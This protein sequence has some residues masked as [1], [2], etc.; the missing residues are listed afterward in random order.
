MQIWKFLK[1]PGTFSNFIQELSTQLLKFIYQAPGQE[2]P[3]VPKSHRH[4]AQRRHP[5]GRQEDARE[6]NR[7]EDGRHQLNSQGAESVSKGHACRHRGGFRQSIRLAQ[8]GQRKN[9]GSAEE[10]GTLRQSVP[11]GE[12]PTELQLCKGP[13]NRGN[14]ISDPDEQHRQ[15]SEG[16][17]GENQA[18]S[19]SKVSKSRAAAAVTFARTSAC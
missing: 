4:Q 11:F 15:A 17:R 3:V 2:V 18:N 19:G 1:H 12:S 5:L 16:T 9:F 13:E 8:E 6:N 14:E 7:D 10:Q